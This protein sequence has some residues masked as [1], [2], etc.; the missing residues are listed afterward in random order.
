VVH[1]PT[2]IA[3][4]PITR[5]EVDSSADDTEALGDFE[6]YVSLTEKRLNSAGVE[7]HL[8][9]TRSFQLRIG[10]KSVTYHP[11]KN[12]IGY[13]FIAPGEG[14]HIEHDVMTDQDIL[15]AARKYFKIV[16]Q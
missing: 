6:Y 13:Y 5:T 1:Q 4:F 2:I 7:I 8:V 12:E 14:P 15:D 9:N 16:I 3:Y 11:K 10:R